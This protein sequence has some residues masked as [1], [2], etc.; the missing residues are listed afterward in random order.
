MPK[1]YTTKE[2]KAMDKEITR[3]SNKV[4]LEIGQIIV[5]NYNDL[6]TY[7]VIKSLHSIIKVLS[8]FY[9]AK[10]YDNLRDDIDKEEELRL[11][12]NDIDSGV[13]SWVLRHIRAL[14]AKGGI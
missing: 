13:D 4:S 1:Q 2:I 5:D 9:Y 12:R 14:N 8:S 3:L 7:I 10:L 11:A 6:N